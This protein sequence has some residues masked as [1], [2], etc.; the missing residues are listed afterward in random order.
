MN[1]MGK[2]YLTHAIGLALALTRHAATAEE[3]TPVE[4]RS[5]KPLT[6]PKPRSYPEQRL[7]SQ[8][9]KLKARTRR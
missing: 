9:R 4:V 3:S 1:R 6:A 2:R 5:E 7:A 8:Q